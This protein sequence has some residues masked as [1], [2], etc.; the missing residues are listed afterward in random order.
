MTRNERQD[1]IIAAAVTFAV[2]LLLLLLL[3]FGGMTF[4]RALLAQASVPEIQ[5][6]DDE[7][8]I[9]PEILQDLGEEYAVA[10]DAPAPAFEGLPQQAEEENTR[11]V[12]PGKN[13]NPAPPVE[14]P[15][16]STKKSPVKAA[17]PPKTSEEKK[18]VTSKMANKFPGQNG[19]SSGMSGTSG[20]GGIGVGISGS[21][22]GRTFKGCPRPSVELQNKVVVEVRVTIDAAGKVVSAT[23]RSKSG[24]ASA[25]ILRA[26]EQAA[27]GARWSEDKDTPSAKG[28]L[29][30][31]ITPK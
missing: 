19:S 31:T 25:A 11:L 1:S 5:T 9:E 20:A 13:V 15:V 30:F 8:F 29:T 24:K 6:E 7:L 14:K 21:V 27:K 16:T 17:D 18:I 12:V 3:F 28:T 4:D 22:S 10:Q 2:A 26:C 23:A